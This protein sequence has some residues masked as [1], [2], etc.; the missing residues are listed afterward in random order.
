MS[1][2]QLTEEKVQGGSLKGTTL[3]AQ[4][5]GCIAPT[6]VYISQEHGMMST[7]NVILWLHG[8]HVKDIKKNVFGADVA[9]GETKLREGVDA[10]GQDVVLVVPFL[11][12]KSGKV[13]QGYGLGKM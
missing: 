2:C 10:A 1:K 5:D 9:V 12:Y 3:F 11:G 13:D 6:A 7:W 4:G 8:H